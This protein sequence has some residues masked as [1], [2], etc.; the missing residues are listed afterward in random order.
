R[1]SHRRCLQWVK[2]RKPQSEY[3]MSASPPIAAVQPRPNKSI[4]GHRDAA[5]NHWWCNAA[6]E[7]PIAVAAVVVAPQPR[8]APGPAGRHRLQAGEVGSPGIAL[9]G[10]SSVTAQ[11][12]PLWPPRDVP[13]PGRVT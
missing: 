2:L 5:L 8:L 6:R 13:P 1:S 12:R 11:S 9:A 3:N 4:A 7:P 10:I